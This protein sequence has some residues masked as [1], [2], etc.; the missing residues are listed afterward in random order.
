M[1]KLI[2][3]DIQ[4]ETFITNYENTLTLCIITNVN[5]SFNE[6]EDF[7]KLQVVGTDTRQ[8]KKKTGTLFEPRYITTSICLIILL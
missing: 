6:T 3:S 8:L 7:G 5:I 2:V 1:R 4:Y